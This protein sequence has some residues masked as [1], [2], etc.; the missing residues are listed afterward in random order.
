M[1]TL[2]LLLVDCRKFGENGLPDNTINIQ[3]KG[4]GGQSFCAFLAHGVY[5]ELEGD[6][7]DYVCKVI[8][9]A[10]STSIIGRVLVSGL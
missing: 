3:M 1:T 4:T 6:A 10:S 9:T 7:N 8:F 5:V 2:W